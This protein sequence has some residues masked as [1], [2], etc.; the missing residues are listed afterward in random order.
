[1]RRQ[2]TLTALVAALVLA[3]ATAL[4]T[5]PAAAEQGPTGG[6]SASY[7][8]TIASLGDSIT[9]GFNAGGWY[10]DWPSRSWS[11]G[12]DSAVNSHRARLTRLNRGAAVR[13]HN[14]ARSGA[15]MVELAGQAAEAVEQRAEYVTVLMGAN[16]ACTARPGGMTRV[17]TYR[18]QFAG[19]MD[20]L[21]NQATPPKV[22]VASIPDLRRLWR[23]G[24]DSAAARNAWSGFD[25]CQSMLAR[26]RSTQK[27]DV[28]RRRRVRQRVIG[29]NTAL[30]EVC[31]TYESCTYDDGAVFGYPFALSHLSRWDY[32]HPNTSGQAVLAEQTWRAG[33]WPTT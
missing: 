12:S 20:T 11:T 33:F 31:A 15:T 32:F 26:P 1:M 30:R 7:P 27:A 25:I 6:R 23:V 10:S 3:V 17:A 18:A 28:D 2:R 24:K 19:A 13:S 8:T 9:R 29:Y 14:D 4:T 5:G 16:D 22:L 21:M